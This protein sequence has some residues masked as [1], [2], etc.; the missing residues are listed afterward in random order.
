MF[1]ESGCNRA[2][3][4]NPEGS[5]NACFQEVKSSCCIRYGDCE[6]QTDDLPFDLRQCL[7]ELDNHDCDELAAGVL[8]R[9]CL[10]SVS[11]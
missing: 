11:N 5:F 9:G 8:P 7:A 4:C 3:V 2:Q 6:A 1:A 10:M